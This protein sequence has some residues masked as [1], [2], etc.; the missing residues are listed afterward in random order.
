MSWCFQTDPELQA[1]LDW[2]DGFV[3]EEILPLETLANEWRRPGG[4]VAYRQIIEP[5]QAEVRRQ[6]LWAAHLPPELGGMGFGQVPLALMHEILGMSRLAPRIFGNSAPDAGNAELLAVGGTDDQKQQWMV[7]LLGGRL[8]SC[9]AMTEPG[10]GADPTLL[11]TTAR[12]DGD[13]WVIDGHK[14]FASSASV[15]DF[16]IVMCKTSHEA[17]VSPYA[18]YSLLIVPTV[19]AGVEIVRDI[20]TMS[21]PEIVEGEPGEH[22]EIRFR[23]AR[24]PFANVV[25][26]AQGIGA[27]F[28]LAQ[29]RLGP[30]RIHHAMRWIGQS[31]RAFDMLCER[32]L[33]RFTHGSLLAEKQMTQQW[34]A[35]SFAEMQ[36]A[37]LLTLNAAWQ[38]DQLLGAGRSPSEARLEIGV[39]KFWG[40]RVLYN[41]IDRAIQIHGSLGYSADLPLEEMYRYA[42]GAR[43]LDGPDE[44]HKVTVARQ[45][46]KTYRAADPPTEHVLTRRSAAMRKFAHVLDEFALSQ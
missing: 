11:S 20:P 14:W 1:R 35:E 2:M 15:S 33:T 36:A 30:G 16:L 44:V 4:D 17:D 46:L 40:A 41:V 21:T 9:F 27:G 38:M 6:G 42:R 37:R 22:A 26:G 43:I 25:G 12:R 5:L 3:R 45:I 32:A 19:T 24:V 23:S 8:R 39:V 18:S 31:R 28:Q 13:E 10:A 7:P 29:K 34:I